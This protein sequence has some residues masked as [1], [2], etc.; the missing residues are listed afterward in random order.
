MLEKYAIL[1][2]KGDVFMPIPKYYEFFAPVMECLKDSKPHLSKETLDYC[3]NYYKLSTEERSE[4][5]Q[6]GQSILS[7][8][9]GWARTYL[10]K[11]GL[12]EKISRGVY[13]ITDEGKKAIANGCD[14]ITYEYMTRYPA[15]VEFAKRTF[16][17]KDSHAPEESEMSNDKS[18]EEMLEDAAAQLNAD[19]SEDLLGELM[20]ISPYDF[21]G[22]V[23]KLL[24]KMG[25]GTLEENKEAVTQKSGDEGIDGIVSA[26]KFGFDS[27]YIQAKQWKPES[28][29]GRPEIQKF[30]GALA[31]QGASKG[32]FITTAQYTKEAVAFAAKQLHSKIVLVDGKQLAKLMIEYDLGVSTVAT[33]KVKRIDS[34]F[35]SEDV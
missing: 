29:V 14:K 34:D 25:Y 10:S 5:L 3:A 6:S 33:Y 27:I 18:P 7:N 17:K 9:V 23:V 2:I 24:I 8:R 21:E 26:D 31:G 4:K 15:F 13:S 1:I 30:L 20:K 22:I 28:V 32:I 19:L 16:N 11:A 35:F 12:V